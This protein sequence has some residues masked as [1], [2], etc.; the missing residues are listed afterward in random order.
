MRRC[1]GIFV[2]LRRPP[3][4]IFSRKDFILFI[5]DLNGSVKLSISMSYWQS[6]DY[7]IDKPGGISTWL[8]FSGLSLSSLPNRGYLIC[9][10][11][12]II[13]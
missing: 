6:T 7:K 8:S 1:S 11:N 3:P 10:R 9:H 5:L 4:P 2:S 13:L 12:A